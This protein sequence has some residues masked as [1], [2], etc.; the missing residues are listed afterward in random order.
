MVRRRLSL[1][2]TDV[3]E[4]NEVIA[5]E[6]INNWK[7]KSY[8]E[9]DVKQLLFSQYEIGHFCTQYGLPSIKPSKRKHKHKG[10]ESFEKPFRKKPTKYYRKQRYKTDDFYKKGKPKEPSRLIS[11]SCNLRPFWYQSQVWPGQ[12]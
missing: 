6:E 9:I 8:H 12:L 1:P 5:D 7:W 2:F 10:K 3:K 11:S 4:D